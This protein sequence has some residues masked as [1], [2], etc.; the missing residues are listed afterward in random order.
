MCAECCCDPCCCS[1]RSSLVSAKRAIQANVAHLDEYLA[2]ADD[3]LIP[4]RLATFATQK[5]ITAQFAAVR[6]LLDARE[7]EVQAQL[8]DTVDRV[9]TRI[10]A[11]RNPAADQRAGNV[12]SIVEI[13]TV[14]VM[15]NPA[16]L[17]LL[18][19]RIAGDSQ[20]SCYYWGRVDT[21]VDVMP[22][23]AEDLGKMTKSIFP[24]TV[25]H[26]L[27]EIPEGLGQDEII[28]LAR[29][30]PDDQSLHARVCVRLLALDCV[31]AVGFAVE[32]VRRWYKSC[33]HPTTCALQVILKAA[34]PGCPQLSH[35]VVYLIECVLRA[36]S[37]HVVLARVGVDILGAVAFSSSSPACSFEPVL[38]SVLAVNIHYPPILAACASVFRNMVCGGYRVTEALFS[39]VLAMI[40]SPP[41]HAQTHVDCFAVIATMGLPETA[42]RRHARDRIPAIG[43][44]MTAFP[45]H[46][47]LQVGAL[48]SLGWMTCDP[49]TPHFSHF[50]AAILPIVRAM[51]KFQD[52]L[53][54]WRYGCVVLSRLVCFMT[55]NNCK[56]MGVFLGAKALHRF[57]D[58]EIIALAAAILLEKCT[59]VTLI[60]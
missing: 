46:E 38:V 45:D 41:K 55:S 49:Y 54:V 3:N 24:I 32:V 12:A 60:R 58:N 39:A 47:E 22:M 28:A 4:L 42:A 26:G 37:G 25:E 57:P 7:S 35:D 30:F 14:L 44:A 10:A 19:T 5:Q 16:D 6:V 18:D 13:D 29:Q 17:A 56:E 9:A 20:M 59:P 15:N 43:E 23:S 52:S 34:S 1:I 27:I 48:C 11:L 50:E 8:I 36:N 2:A 21:D 51:R 33:P 53:L 40:S 31:L